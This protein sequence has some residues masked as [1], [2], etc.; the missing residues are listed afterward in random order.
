MRCKLAKKQKRNLKWKSI[1]PKHSEDA[2]VIWLAELFQELLPWHPNLTIERFARD[3]GVEPHLISRLV[4]KGQ[5]KK[6]RR[7]NVI[8][9]HGTTDDKARAI[10]EEGFRMGEREGKQRWIWFT[11]NSN[12]AR[13]HAMNRSTERGSPPVVFCCNIDLRKYPHFSRSGLHYAH[14]A[15]RHSRISQGV[16][17]RISCLEEVAE[18]ELEIDSEDEGKLVDVTITKTSGKSGI[19]RWVNQYLKLTYE[20]AVSEEHPVVE[21][22]F[23]WVETQYLS[24]RKGPISEDEM[25]TQMSKISVQRA[26]KH[27]AVG[28]QVISKWVD[29]GRLKAISVRGHLLLPL[30]IQDIHNKR[31]RNIINLWHGTT[32]DRAKVIM[33]EGFRRG[34]IWF[35]NN[36][37]FARRHAVGRARQRKKRP[38][39]ISCEIDL[40]KYPSFGRPSK[41]IYVFYSFANSKV[42][43]KEVI[44]EVSVLKDKSSKHPEEEN[45]K[46]K[47]VDIIVTKTAGKLGV[48]CWINRYLELKGETAL[49]EDHP[50]VEA[51][52]KWVEAEYA[53][54]RDEPISNGEML[55]QMMTHLKQ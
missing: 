36:P 10:M 7:K 23:K 44:R 11:Q 55:T 17:R 16:I 18:D 9:W 43:G 46:Q 34:K 15:F 48:L 2:H 30:H 20:E 6:R 52:F 1:S 39:V 12:F 21:A 42:I 53:Q 33:E 8:L 26:A 31:Y 35:T 38:V 45:D 22:I 32:E 29:G 13:T 4:P 50:S 51:I 3:H 25:F 27:F 40:E 49:S 54:G 5:G 24:G 14:Y 19:L 37:T 41:D 28:T 47:S